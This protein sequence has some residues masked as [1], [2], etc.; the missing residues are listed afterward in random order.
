MNNELRAVFEVSVVF[1]LRG[2]FIFKFSALDSAFRFQFFF[3]LRSVTLQMTNKN[4]T[5]IT[6]NW[7]QNAN[8]RLSVQAAHTQNY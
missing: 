8:K 6:K 4:L 5:K 1:G 3:S 2:D 7:L